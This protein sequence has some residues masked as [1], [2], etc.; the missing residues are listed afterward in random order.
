MLSVISEA[1][2]NT[3]RSLTVEVYAWGQEN[4]T[5]CI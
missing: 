2:M 1:L 5:T 4:F 3:N